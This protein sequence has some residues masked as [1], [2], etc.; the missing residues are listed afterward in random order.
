M[1]PDC[2]LLFL[3]DGSEKKSSFHAEKHSMTLKLPFHRK[4]GRNSPENRRFTGVCTVTP[5]RD[6]NPK[7]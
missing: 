3:W 5:R 2:F 7:K 1:H 6:P 4:A